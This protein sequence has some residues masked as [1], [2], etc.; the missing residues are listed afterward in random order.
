MNKLGVISLAVAVLAAAAVP[1]YKWVDEAGNIHYSDQPPPSG[2]SGE[3]VELLPGPRQ[4]DAVQAQ[5][6]VARLRT[7]LAA[8]RERRADVREQERLQREIAEA[9]RVERL[10]L[11]TAAQQN[12]HTLEVR[13]PVYSI[14]EH[15]ERVYLEDEQR[16]AEMARFRAE[17]A[18]YCD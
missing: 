18:T 17:I 15:G 12:L 8:S 16:P 1:V 13:M 3:A 11:C 14:D 4:E 2:Q 7:E 10:R 9:E 6:R 5:A